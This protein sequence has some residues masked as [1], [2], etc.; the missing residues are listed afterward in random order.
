MRFGSYR[1]DYEKDRVAAKYAGPNLPIPEVHEVGE[2]FGGAYAVSTRA[3]A[4]PLD[5]L[6]E[7]GYRRVVGG[8]N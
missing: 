8:Q 7:A 2:V 3:Y 5:K 1:E 6:D 4:E